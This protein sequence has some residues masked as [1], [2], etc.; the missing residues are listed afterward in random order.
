MP[1]LVAKLKW[2]TACEEQLFSFGAFV[3]SPQPGMIW[4]YQPENSNQPGMDEG[5]TRLFPNFSGFKA[6]DR[7]TLAFVLFSSKSQ[8]TIPALRVFPQEELLAVIAFYSRHPAGFLCCRGYEEKRRRKKK[9]H[10]C[11]I[12]HHRRIDVIGSVV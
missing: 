2:L 11:L 1:L 8:S 3:F 12:S 6:V 10:G 9:A 7:L 5:I 4:G